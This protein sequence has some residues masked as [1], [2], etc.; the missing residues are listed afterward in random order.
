MKRLSYFL[1]SLIVCIYFSEWNCTFPSKSLS[2]KLSAK[3]SLCC[4]HVGGESDNSK[5]QGFLWSRK[6]RNSRVDR[7]ALL[8]CVMSNCGNCKN[9][10]WILGNK[11]KFRFYVCFASSQYPLWSMYSSAHPSPLSPHHLC[12]CQSPSRAYEAA[13]LWSAFNLPG[14]PLSLTP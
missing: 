7:K 3:S 13:E 2:D 8:R 6:K 5:T 14:A 11:I 12:P 9:N 4:L 1:S 10:W